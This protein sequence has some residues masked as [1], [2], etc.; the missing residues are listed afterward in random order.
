MSRWSQD[1]QGVGTDPPHIWDLTGGVITHPE[2]WHLVVATEASST[3]STGIHSCYKSN[4][5]M[6]SSR[7][8][9]VHSSSHRL[10]GG[11]SASVHAGIH[12][13]H[14]GPGSGPGHSPPPGLGLD[15]T[16]P[17]GPVLGQPPPPPGQTL[18]GLILDSLPV[19]RMTDRCKNI[20]F[21][22][23][24]LRTV[25]TSKLRQKATNKAPLNHLRNPGS[26]RI[27]GMKLEKQIPQKIYHFYRPQ[28]KVVF[29]QVSVCPQ[30]VSWILVHCSALLQCSRYT[31]YWNAFLLLSHDKAMHGLG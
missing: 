1:V 24:R 25:I 6:H 8:H 20:T 4:T 27:R 12:P 18:P 30:S 7:M 11:L 13:L 19:D 5:R 29:S 2:Y 14:P 28:G 16:L 17:P 9:A 15:T 26:A 3:H 21:P 10:E 23:L 22:L 31:S